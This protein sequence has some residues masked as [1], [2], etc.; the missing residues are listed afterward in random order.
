MPNPEYSPNNPLYYDEPELYP[1]LDTLI[2]D[3]CAPTN[4]EEAAVYNQNRENLEAFFRSRLMIPTETSD[5][6]RAVF[7]RVPG[8]RPNDPQR[9][10]RRLLSAQAREQLVKLA[11]DFRLSTRE[12]SLGD[13]NFYILLSRKDTPQ[14]KEYND[15]IIN[16]LKTATPKERGRM[17]DARIRSC[18]ELYMKCLKG[19]LS[20]RDII[21][22]LHAL[23]RVQDVVVNAPN[24]LDL[25]SASEKK[26][27]EFAP[28]TLEMLQHMNENYVAMNVLMQRVRAIANP[29][30]E[31]I[32]IDS[33]R[34]VSREDFDDMEQQVDNVYPG[35]HDYMKSLSNVRG[36]ELAIRELN[37]SAV[38]ESFE[39]AALANKGFFIGSRAYSRALRSMSKLAKVMED[40]DV[41][42]SA[43]D[44]EKVKPMLEETIRK[45]GVY[46]SSKT[47]GRFKN[48]REERRYHAM[49][50]I[51]NSCR[52][53]LD[54]LNLPEKI[55]EVEA[56]SFRRPNVDHEYPHHF[57]GDVMK[58]L[59]ECYG[60]N[61]SRVDKKTGNA[62]IPASDV[63]T[64]ADDLR[65]DIYSQLKEI[66]SNESK[67]DKN[68][69]RTVM[70]SMVVLEMVKGGRKVNVLGQY[71]AGAV[72]TTLADN[73]IGLITTIR[74]N[75]YFQRM[76]QNATPEMLH[77]FIMT[78]G[79][80]AIADSMERIAESGK[81]ASEKQPDLQLEKPPVA[82][83]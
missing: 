78:N 57:M 75:P 3:S 58:K 52:K 17:F 1:L 46:L 64:A 9:D 49:E 20:D 5:Q 8:Y 63:G 13:R 79:A 2:S 36:Q 60:V 11:M 71:V 24:L 80:K 45:C 43:E 6:I 83:V 32:D 55:K 47:P 10:A 4:S 15:N 66:L 27:V 44:V 59:Q 53:T 33:F 70:A 56:L 72:E 65:A 34:Y 21:E 26:R 68:L 39:E 25:R 40:M 61:N 54:F 48:A 30:Y 42:P 31:F 77:H 12:E 50:R 62:A 37:K 18:W 7:G 29:I 69:A 67:Y 73:P 16:R 38:K 51:M 81:V 74:D 23:Q 19:E 41:F 28:K 14:D 22:N 76:T 35:M 82:Q